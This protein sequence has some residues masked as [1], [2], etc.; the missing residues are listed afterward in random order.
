MITRPTSNP[1]RAFPAPIAAA[2]IIVA[3]R[4]VIADSD[5]RSAPRRRSQSKATIAPHAKTA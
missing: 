1:G 2:V 4:R 5:G 3:T